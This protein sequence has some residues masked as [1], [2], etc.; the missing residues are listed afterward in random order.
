MFNKNKEKKPKFKVGQRVKPKEKDPGVFGVVT[1]VWTT[2]PKQV[3]YSVRWTNH[4]KV[5]IEVEEDLKKA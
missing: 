1:K 5:M 3:K 2:D 4:T